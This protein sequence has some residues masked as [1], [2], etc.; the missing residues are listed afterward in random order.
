MGIGG[1]EF[2]ITLKLKLVPLPQLFEPQTVTLPEIAAGLKSTVMEFVFAPEVTVTPE[3]TVQ[4]YPLA[5][6]ISGTV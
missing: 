2:T 5:F 6:G 1:I 4:I 3:G